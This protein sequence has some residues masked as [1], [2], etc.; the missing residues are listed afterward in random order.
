M[1][2]HIDPI[3]PP[4]DSELKAIKRQKAL[5]K[6]HHDAIRDQKDALE[7]KAR[8]EKSRKQEKLKEKTEIKPS[9]T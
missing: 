3:L 4:T 2:R 9:L 8:E 1:Q 5:D 7:K 6:A